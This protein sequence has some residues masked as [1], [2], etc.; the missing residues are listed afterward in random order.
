[1]SFS[2]SNVIEYRMILLEYS[3]NEIGCKT[4]VRYILSKMSKG[5]N[6][7]MGDPLASYCS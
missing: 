7:R 4:F 5:H 3:T 6:S 2:I 1:M